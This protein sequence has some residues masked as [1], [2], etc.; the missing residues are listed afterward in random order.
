[1]PV[2]S[3]RIT[4][5]L[6]L[7][8]VHVHAVQDEGRQVRVTAVPR[9]TVAC[10]PRCGHVSAAVHSRWWSTIR[11]LP[12]Q[13]RPCYLRLQRRRFRCAHGCPPFREPIACVAKYQR[14]TVRYQQH[15]E[16][17]CRSTAL[18][19]A[20]QREGIGYK[21]LE[22]C[23]YT[24]AGR[25]VASLQHQ[26]LPRWLGIDEFSGKRG[27]RLHVAITALETPRLWD[28]LPTKAANP[29]F[30]FFTQYSRAERAQVEVVVHDMDRGLASWCR[31]L[32]PR[33]LPVIDKWHVHRTVLK[34]LERVRKRAYQRC[35]RADGRRHVRSAYYL[36]RRR[37]ARLPAPE[38]ARLA[39]VLAL[40]RELAQA[41]AWKEAFCTWYDTRQRRSAADT[42]LARLEI[43]LAQIPQ[44]RRLAGTLAQ[45]RDAILNYFAV[46]VTNGFT[47]GT[48][49]KLKVT[50][51]VGYGQRNW[52]RFRIR[53]VNEC[54]RP[55]VV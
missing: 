7:Q 41:H 13:G 5:T 11:D 44:F 51:R 40:D 52:A 9:Q 42:E 35:L 21:T 45:W 20:S 23:Y 26:P 54:A 6:G 17:A 25:K 19:V 27:Q 43:S 22:R 8:E 3:N 2:Q 50:K 24:R 47:E 48:N 10:C 38:Q 55:A 36:L 15:L 12:V 18:T 37:A 33:A 32:F 4:V 34:H 14:Q 49:N 46:R 28:V 30:D 1:M 31:T 16:A 53:L 39:A 29:L